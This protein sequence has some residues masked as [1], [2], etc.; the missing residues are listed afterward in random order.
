MTNIRLYRDSRGQL[1]GF[2]VI[3]HTFSAPAGEDIVCASVSAV[4]QTAA[5]ALETVAG[6]RPTVAIGD[7]FLSV[8]LP[9]GL[10]PRQKDIARIILRTAQQGFMDMAS[11]YPEFIRIR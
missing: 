7:G 11:A 3:G 6:I 5:N 4:S 1:R 8:R 10:T 2:S 9:K